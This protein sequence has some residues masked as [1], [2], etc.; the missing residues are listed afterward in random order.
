MSERDGLTSAGA[1]AALARADEL[2]ASVRERGRWLVRFQLAYG[3]MSLVAVL[4]LG[5][6]DWPAGI[7]ISVAFWAVTLPPLIFY[8]VRQPVA[9]RG[10]ARSHLVMMA[11]W[12]V[13][14]L[15]VLMPGTQMQG[16]PG[17]WVP[18]AVAVS[19]PGFVAAYLTSRRVTGRAA[20]P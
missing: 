12:T 16:E 10:M 17:W 11:A 2:R 8:A 4:M 15:A 13:L 14:Y 6:V 1:A 5:L 7:V 20:R 3:A 9:H 18:G 19:L